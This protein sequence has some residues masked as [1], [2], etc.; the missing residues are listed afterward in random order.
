MDHPNKKFLNEQRTWATSL[1]LGPWLARG[2]RA[3]LPGAAVC[4][5]GGSNGY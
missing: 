4:R 5:N 3:I 1:Q 2:P